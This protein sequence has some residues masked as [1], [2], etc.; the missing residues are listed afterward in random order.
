[1]AKEV[2]AKLS[3]TDL[4][5]I[6]CGN[7]G[8]PKVNVLNI[9]KNTFDTMKAE[10]DLCHQVGVHGFGTFTPIT[11]KAR[12]GRNPQT[13]ETVQVPAKST[14]KFKPTKPSKGKKGEAEGASEE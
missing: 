1:M 8:L 11:K 13:G 9:M 12:V 5:E 6:V 7:T 2:A 10:L 14:F 3:L 4:A